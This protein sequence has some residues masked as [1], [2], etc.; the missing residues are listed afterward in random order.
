MQVVL[1]EDKKY[2]PSAEEVYGQGTET[3]L[4]DEDAQPLEE[5]IIAPEKL[6]SFEVG[7]EAR[8]GGRERGRERGRKGGSGMTLSSLQVDLRYL[9][10]VC[11][12]G[13]RVNRC[14]CVAGHLH[15]GKVRAAHAL[16]HSLTHS[17]SPLLTP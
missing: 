8:E 5:P 9:R 6:R 3:L 1:H 12:R 2:Y 13:A 16:P 15:H 4:Q 14:V 7:D 17:L 10:E 11:M